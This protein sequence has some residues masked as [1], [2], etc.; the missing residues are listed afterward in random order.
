MLPGYIAYDPY[1]LIKT[2]VAS[3]VFHPILITG[4]SGIGKTLGP[5]QACAELGREFVRANIT[6]ESD[7]DDLVG[8]FR[9]GQGETYFDLGPVPLAMLRGCPL[10]LDEVDKA[11][12]KIE[13]LKA[14]LEG[15]PLI[16]KKIRTR[17][18]P[19]PGFTVFATANTK[20]Q[21][22]ESGKFVTSTVLDEAFL[23]R[24]PNTI[25]Q[26]YPTVEQETLIL[27]GYFEALGGK[28][29][30]SNAAFCTT[31]A[32]WAENI[33]QAAAG[34]AAE[35]TMSTR[36]LTFVMKTYYVLGSKDRKNQA[37][38]LNLCLSRYDDTTRKTFKDL[39]N[40]HVDSGAAS[41]VGAAPPGAFGM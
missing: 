32:K 3:K 18:E 36:R 17:I 33:R 38:A 6:I 30:R 14:L 35:N 28:M 25:E 4:P 12:P 31:L 8:G 9:L 27:K 15:E 29:D 24:F 7:E 13:C 2:V 23:E 19:S 1:P 16:I 11:S 5:K 21:G 20:G 39:Y 26:P 41:N 37:M 10:V 34:N 40:K 22:D